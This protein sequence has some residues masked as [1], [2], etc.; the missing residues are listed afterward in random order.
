MTII[1]IYDYGSG[2]VDNLKGYKHQ[3]ACLIAH[4]RINTAMLMA[5]VYN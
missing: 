1:N 4:L 2:K 5:S 3:K